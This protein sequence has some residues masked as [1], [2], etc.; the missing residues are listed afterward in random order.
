LNL[1]DYAFHL[2]V[3]VRHGGFA[4]LKYDE[5]NPDQYAFVQDHSEATLFT[6][7]DLA[8]DIRQKICQSTWPRNEFDF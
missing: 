6:D 8:T 2:C 4:F 1:T 3:A 7:N 5:K